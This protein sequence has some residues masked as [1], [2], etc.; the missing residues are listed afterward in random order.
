MDWQVP[1]R[2]PGQVGTY[3]SAGTVAIQSDET[4][5]NMDKDECIAALKDEMLSLLLAVEELIDKIHQHK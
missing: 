3:R 5:H 4:L 2:V 1:W